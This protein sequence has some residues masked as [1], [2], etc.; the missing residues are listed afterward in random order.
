MD[1]IWFIQIDGTHEGP[2]SVQDLK[3]DHRIVPDTLVWREGFSDWVPIRKVR[4]LKEVFADEEPRSPSKDEEEK[5]EKARK[6]FGTG[7]DELALDLHRDF[8]PMYW[9]L[10][11]LIIL[12]YLLYRLFI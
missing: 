9:L 5:K 3:R 2:Y 4:E 11:I 7:R 1:K 8:P 10:F 6:A 12:S